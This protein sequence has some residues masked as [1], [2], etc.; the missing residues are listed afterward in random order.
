[1]S[2]VDFTADTSVTSTRDVLH[3][4]P[5]DT[6]EPV[7]RPNPDVILRTVD[8]VDFRFYK[9]LL[10][11]ASPFFSN[12]FTLPQ[13]ESLDTTD[14]VQN[15]CGLPVIPVSETS[16]IMQKLLSLCSPIY[17]VKVP[18]L[19]NL[20]IVMSLLDAADK[21]E[22]ER[23]GKY[24]LNLI[25]A[26]TFLE[27]E[28]MRVFAIACRY[29]AEKETTMAARYMLR[30]AVWE[31]EYVA[32]LDFISGSNYQRLV[33]YHANCGHAM[34][35]LGRLW[36]TYPLPPLDCKCCRKQGVSRLSAREY[37][38]SVIEALRIRPC[39]ETLLRQEWI[40]VMVR[41]A[42]SC[43]TCRERAPRKLAKYA[44]ELATA[45]EAIIS[46]VGL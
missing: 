5:V 37:Q 38:D 35:Q 8:N 32:E 20:D 43:Q 41:K 13:P 19:E 31:P 23:V 33:K 14:N 30:F 44:Q 4:E 46:L 16:T 24:I 2:Q 26:P 17:D 40:D 10:S 36:S 9:L 42:G 34:A 27:R 11:M 7:D 29:R 6:G 39:V 18:A 45:V 12:M 28:P 25:T 22:M 21:Y 1:M 3:T 15:K